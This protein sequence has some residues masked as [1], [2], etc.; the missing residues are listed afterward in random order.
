MKFVDEALVRI[1]AGDGGNGCIS[2]RREKY[3]PKGGPDGG[4]GGNGGDVYLVADSNLNTLVDYQFQK[5][6]NAGR[7]ENGR[8]ANCTGARGEDII[9]RVPVGSRAIDNETGEIIGDLLRDGQKLMVAKGGFMGLGNTRLKGPVKRP[10][11][12]KTNGPL[13]DRSFYV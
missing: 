3:I 12:Q 4:D 2:F 6:F 13:G 1:E 7:G 8:G 11:S 9:L 5:F 10:Q